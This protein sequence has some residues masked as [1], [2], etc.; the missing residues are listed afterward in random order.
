MKNLVSLAVFC[1]IIF[2]SI[3][4]FAQE[5]TEPATAS[6]DDKDRYV[7]EQAEL[8]RPIYKGLAHE[9][10]IIG[11]LPNGYKAVVTNSQ[12]EEIYKIQKDYNEL[13]ELIKVR[14]QLLE[15]ERD[16][17]IDALLNADQKHRIKTLNGTLESEK[18]LIRKEATTAPRL[19]RR[20]VGQNA[21]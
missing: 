18:H 11:R 12:R 5:N 21:E 10:K 9:K 4:L 13:I 19:L 2:G 16:N 6:N 7:L 14:M 15:S 17:K 20:V 3:T 1:I 8:P